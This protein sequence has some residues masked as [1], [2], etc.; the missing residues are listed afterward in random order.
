[1]FTIRAWTKFDIFAIAGLERECFPDAWTE[2]T[3]TAE[4]ARADVFGYVAERDG[5]VV[6]FACGTALFEDAEIWKVAVAESE[7]GKGLGGA[8]TD[9]LL[10]TAKERGATRTF[11]EVRVGNRS[12]IGLYQS[13]GFERTRERKRYYADGEDA[14]EMKKDL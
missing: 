3:W 12:A 1:M 9:A 10:Q 14:L 6:G 8:L 13:R 7:R 11:L 4:F 2:E 5:K